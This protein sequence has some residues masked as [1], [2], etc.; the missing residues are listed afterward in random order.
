MFEKSAKFYADW[1]DHKGTR[2]RKSFNTARAALQFEAAQKEIAH[3]KP[4]AQGRTLPRFSAPDTRGTA[5]RRIKTTT[6]R[7][8]S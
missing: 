6:R 8:A 2:K 1:R 4:R 3:P 5:Q 7:K